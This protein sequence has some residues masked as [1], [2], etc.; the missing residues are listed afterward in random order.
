MADEE[1]PILE[2]RTP[3]P[4]ARRSVNFAGC[5]LPISIL[6]FALGA[7]IVY[8]GTGQLGPDRREYFARGLGIILVA[9]AVLAT[10]LVR[11]RKR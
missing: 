4:I 6:T 2:Y 10:Y 8:G 1:R 3:L 9:V 7:L 11:K 5:L